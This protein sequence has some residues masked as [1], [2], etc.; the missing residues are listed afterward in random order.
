LQIA[1]VGSFE[2]HRV[3]GVSNLHAVRDGWRVLKTIVREAVDA[4]VEQPASVMGSEL[5]S[6]AA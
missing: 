1:E 4:R 3:H 6:E 5:S 2:S